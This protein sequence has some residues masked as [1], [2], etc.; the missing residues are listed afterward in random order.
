MS[1]IAE[2]T[3]FQKPKIANSIVE[4]VGGTYLN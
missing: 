4:V 3:P 2:G 1:F